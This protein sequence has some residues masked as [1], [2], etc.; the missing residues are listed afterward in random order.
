MKAEE[1]INSV[2]LG[3]FDQESYVSKEDAMK[4]IRMARAETATCRTCE[5]RQRWECGGR[6]I[7]YCSVRRSKRTFNGLLKIKV[8]NQACMLYKGGAK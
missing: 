4:A 5:Y 7:Q 1:Y 2:T 3:G 6:V 8:T